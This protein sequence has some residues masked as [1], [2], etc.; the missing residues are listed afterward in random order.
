M[1]MPTIYTHTKFS[2]GV[3]YSYSRYIRTLILVLSYTYRH[4]RHK[5]HVTNYASQVGTVTCEPASTPCAHRA[6]LEGDSSHGP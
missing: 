3:G 4:T 6:L 5:L 2:T 1:C